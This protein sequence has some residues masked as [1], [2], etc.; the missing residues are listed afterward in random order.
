[1]DYRATPSPQSLDDA[2][3]A[4]TGDA[5]GGAFGRNSTPI[6]SQAQA[7]A[8]NYKVGRTEVQGLRI[9]IEQPQG[10][11]RTGT[12]PN[13]KVWESRMAAH[14]GYF[15]STT[16][17]D[18]DGVDC[19]VGPHPESETAYVIN[20]T[21]QD[22]GFDEHKT[23][24]GFAHE[25]HAR[26]AYQASYEPGWTGLGSIVPLSITQ[27]RW[28]LQNGNTRAELTTDQLPLER[29]K[30][31][32]KVYWND[33]QPKGVS[34]DQVLY[35]C[36]R[37][38]GSDG[39]LLDP[40][41]M[42]EIM[43]DSEG[44]IALDSLVVPYAQ[45]QRLS[46]RLRLI[47]DRSGGAVKVPAVQ[48]SEPFRARGV[49]SVATVFEL[50]D[51]QTVSIFFHNPDTTPTKIKPTDEMV[52]W[53]WVLNKKDITIVVAPERGE[54]LNPR[55]VASRIMK[56]AEKNSAAFQKANT[57]RAA[58][59]ENIQGI[60]DRIAEKEG[61]LSDLV[62]KIDVAA[63]A[64]AKRDAQASDEDARQGEFNQRGI[65]IAKII[66][67]AGWAWS[68][69][70]GG[71]TK[72]G[73]T[74]WSHFGQPSNVQAKAYAEFTIKGGSLTVHQT[75]TDDLIV[76]VADTASKV[77]E[78]AEGAIEAAPVNAKPVVPFMTSKGKIYN[79][80]GTAEVAA[81]WAGICC[82]S[83]NTSSFWYIGQDGG[84][85][86]WN[87]LQA[88]TY[89]G[90]VAEV[91]AKG[92]DKLVKPAPEVSA[93]I[94]ADAIQAVI[95]STVPFDNLPP[96]WIVMNAPRPLLGDKLAQG[97]FLTGRF[98][99]AIDPSVEFAK[100]LF[101]RNVKDDASIVFVADAA[102]QEAM[103]LETISPEYQDAYRKMAPA[104]R[105]QAIE[106]FVRKLS[107]GKTYGELKEIARVARQ[108]M[109]ERAA[110]GEADP[111]A[112]VDAAYAFASATEAFKKAV[113]ASVDESDHSAFKS[114]KEIDQRAKELGA[115]VD[116]DVQ[117]LA[118]DS[119]AG[120]A[121]EDDFDPEAEFEAAEDVTLDGDFTGHP[122]R[123]NQFKKTSES[124]HAAVRASQHARHAEKAGSK[125]GKSAH[126][127]AHYAHMAASEAATGKAKE[128][129]KTMAKFHGQRAGLVRGKKL[130][131][132][133]D[134]TRRDPKQIASERAEAST[135]RKFGTMAGREAEDHFKKIY[136][137]Q[138]ELLTGKV[139]TDTTLDRVAE[140]DHAPTYTDGTGKWHSYTIEA[141]K[142]KSE[143][144]LR[145][146][147]KD[148]T[149]SADLGEKMD[150]PNPKAGQYRDEAHYASME[151]QRRKKG[152][153]KL[154]DVTLDVVKPDTTNDKK[155]SDIYALAKTDWKAADAKVKEYGADALTNDIA[156]SFLAF[157]IDAYKREK[158]KLIFL[159][160]AFYNLEVDYSKKI[161]QGV[162]CS[163]LSEGQAAL[164][165]AQS[166]F[167]AII[168]TAWGKGSFEYLKFHGSKAS[169]SRE[170]TGVAPDWAKRRLDSAT[171]DAAETINMVVGTISKDGKVRGRAV[172]ST[173]DGK[174][175]V[176]VGNTGQDRVQYS[177][178]ETPTWSEDD[179]G[180]MVDLLL[181]MPDKLEPEPERVKPNPP[182]APL[183]H[184]I[185]D[186]LKALGW[187]S[188][189]HEGGEDG[190]PA[191]ATASITLP[192]GEPVDVELGTANFGGSDFPVYGVQ[193]SAMH[194][195]FGDKSAKEIAL[196]IDTLVR[197]S[198]DE[199]ERMTAE[200]EGDGEALEFTGKTAA[201]AKSVM[202]ARAAVER[203]GGE[204]NMGDFNNSGTAG[205]FDDASIPYGICAQIAKNGAGIGRLAVEEDGAVTVYVGLSG[206]DKV[207]DGSS[208]DGW[209]KS[210]MGIE[211]MVA[212][213]FARA[214]QPAVEPTP[215][216]GPQ[217]APAETEYS[218]VNAAM[219]LAPKDGETVRSDDPQ[220][221]EKLERKLT[222]LMLLQDFMKKTNR[223]LKAGKDSELLAMGFTQANIDNL[224]KPDF[225]GRVGFPDYKLT[226]N[227]GVISTTR[228]RLEAIQRATVVTPEPE[229]TVSDTNTPQESTAEVLKSL[230]VEKGYAADGSF[231]TK[232]DVRIEVTDPADV[233]EGF[234]E[235]WV[236]VD[237]NWVS[238][239]DVLFDGGSWFRGDDTREKIVKLVDKLVAETGPLQKYADKINSTPMSKEREG[240]NAKA[241][242]RELFQSVIDGTNPDILE[243]ELASQIEAAFTRNSA[244]VEM[245]SLFSQAVNA[246]TQA[247][248]NATAG[249]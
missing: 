188:V 4:I 6:P 109:D 44:V 33:E 70:D 111:I 186:E 165:N 35:E 24:V 249:V 50:S 230:L 79:A 125:D 108:A 106:S 171:L 129:H 175:M 160:S 68:A 47:M 31:M 222:A 208:A 72:Q 41:T 89:E 63:E 84:E 153:R 240:F 3:A 215:E 30:T 38:D 19:F 133:L 107:V 140:F 96:D 170:Y 22:G 235:M 245:V 16:G 64:K 143:D 94:N 99:A 156:E 85:R 103:A 113:A 213:L 92:L 18:G 127:A 102:L 71:W 152:G 112:A 234:A 86:S 13:G 53:K 145:F 20:Q 196:E 198:D 178:G 17:R 176:F 180:E 100:N 166:L 15:E 74:I 2:Y 177:T 247:M 91:A 81:D 164:R 110:I 62:A 49:T 61:I 209:T 76:P 39:L 60:R 193:N 26:E 217:L 150:P 116:W 167:K 192:S 42:A 189:L 142:H 131:S 59:L 75:V 10:S 77:L 210:R 130:D 23:M 5:H 88:T 115:T 11:V 162:P 203:Q 82:N 58:R 232:G 141:M 87:K 190:E 216:P 248:L 124:S 121:D 239:P 231:F 138:L 132:V 48:V 126:R 57:T 65:E 69:E 8:G 128:Y 66:T 29:K 206:T 21:R 135:V 168:N 7:I 9:A 243:P 158:P 221:I 183:Q 93:T 123:G 14:Y 136:L 212:S 242:D 233:E 238:P 78:I 45:L 43:A 52:S 54:D 224:K 161:L 169:T 197:Y 117:A 219:K 159:G 90:A 227:N 118:L 163:K 194:F 97:E 172:V 229:T 179:C 137:G 80:D 195:K 114:A 200:V 149:E 67:D 211:Q 157:G 244:D 173:G 55:I 12:D 220:A 202:I 83:D 101:D 174:S 95:A 148:A 237:G 184:L 98:Y 120:D 56:L 122:F 199:M 119:V 46:D 104:K 201:F 146:I 218:R 236:R 37:L 73:V 51:G 27:L 241:A 144:A 36:R 223:L 28:W 181:A 207:S 139:I 204:L 154:D 182:F 151:I 226:N 155:I 40:L 228:K 185:V 246:Y 147:I 32:N 25:R 187:D 225:G 205:L 134:A 34:L 105:S 191:S 1:M 214:S